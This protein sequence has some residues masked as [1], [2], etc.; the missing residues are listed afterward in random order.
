MIDCTGAVSLCRQFAVFGPHSRLRSACLAIVLMLFAPLAQ[1]HDG[2][3]CAST[4]RELDAVVGIPSFS[5]RWIEISMND[6]K[7]LV[8][9]II[10]RNGLL[11]VE[12]MKTGEGLW[13]ELSGIICK[14]NDVVEMRVTKE[15]IHLGPAANW[16][17][18]RSLTNGGVVTLQQ[19][20]YGQLQIATSGWSGNFV[21][22]LPD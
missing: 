8:V 10:E 4:A 22:V 14:A 17:L 6:G 20:Q 13:A 9:T 12:F 1:A 15:Q 11:L 2:A 3:N 21:P 19:R 5:P 18:S 16:I 7:P